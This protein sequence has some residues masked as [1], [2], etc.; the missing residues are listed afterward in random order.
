MLSLQPLDRH[1]R[2]LSGFYVT[3][4][5]LLRPLTKRFGFAIKAIPGQHLSLAIVAGTASSYTNTSTCS[6]ATVK[7]QLRLSQ[8]CN[9]AAPLSRSSCKSCLGDLANTSASPGQHAFSRTLQRAVEP[10]QW[11]QAL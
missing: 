6:S 7:L 11:T 4:R 1:L 9:L 2:L 10:Q 8:L 3:V 5:G